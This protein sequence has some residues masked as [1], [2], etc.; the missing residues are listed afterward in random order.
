VINLKAR[1]QSMR[2]KNTSQKRIGLLKRRLEMFLLEKGFQMSAWRRLDF[3]LLILVLKSGEEK[4]KKI[5][6]CSE[7]PGVVSG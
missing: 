6:C 2:R 3:S 1:E 5:S 7:K 4:K